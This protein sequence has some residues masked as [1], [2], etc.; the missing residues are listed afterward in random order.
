MKKYSLHKCGDYYQ[1]KYWERFIKQ[2]FPSYGKFWHKY[3]VPISNRPKN[4]YIKT[5]EEL[6]EM[7]RS[8]HD[9][10]IA[11]LQYTVLR[12]LIRAYKIRDNN[13]Y[14]Q[15]LTLDRFVEFIVRICAATDVADEFLERFTNPKKYKVWDE[16]DG[17]KARKNWRKKNKY[18]LQN[19][20]D[21]RNTLLHW[22]LLPT[23]TN[24]YPKIGL[25]KKYCDWRKVTLLEMRPKEIKKD[26]TNF[27][28]KANYIWLKVLN[29]LED[30]WKMILKETFSEELNTNKDYNSTIE[31]TTIDIKTRPSEENNDQDTNNLE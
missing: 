4:I 19:I 23:I 14:K 3:I 18:K 13:E 31:E 26:F 7:G 12:H 6:K 9:V 5:D 10:Q 21:Y 22:P 27:N 11:Q 2:D 30:N 25:Q 1:Q 24:E 8:E 15:Y 17:E 16:A 20:R 29:Y 28:I